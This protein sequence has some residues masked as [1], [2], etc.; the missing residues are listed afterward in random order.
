MGAAVG[1]LL[2]IKLGHSR[3]LRS[4]QCVGDM[5]ALE[6][7]ALSVGQSRTLAGCPIRVA[8]LAAPGNRRSRLH[9][10]PMAAVELTVPGAEPQ[11]RW[12]RRHEGT[13]Q[14]TADHGRGVVCSNPEVTAVATREAPCQASTSRPMNGTGH[15]APRLQIQYSRLHEPWLSPALYVLCNSRMGG[16]I[17]ANLVALM[18]T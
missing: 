2:G 9:V 10:A 7:P 16:S 17:S 12:L 8:S 3:M 14:L 1:R 13:A 15:E 11:E 4:Q 18:T 5:T 6:A